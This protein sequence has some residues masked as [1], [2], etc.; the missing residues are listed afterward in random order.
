MPHPRLR[1][2]NTRRRPV[3]CALCPSVARANPVRDGVVTKVRLAAVAAVVQFDM[4]D[5]VRRPQIE[6][7]TGAGGL[8]W[9]SA[10]E[11]IKVAV[12]AGGTLTIGFTQRRVRYRELEVVI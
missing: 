4:G 7:E 9:T 11:R 10:A 6:D 1:R 3:A 2:S 12:D 5:L 8:R